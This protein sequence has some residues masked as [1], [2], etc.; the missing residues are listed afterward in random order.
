M[1]WLIFMEMRLFSSARHQPLGHL[2]SRIASAFLVSLLQACFACCSRPPFRWS[3]LLPASFAVCM[4]SLSLS[5]SFLLANI[6]RPICLSLSYGQPYMVPACLPC[7]LSYPRCDPWKGRSNV[8]EWV[9]QRL[10]RC[11]QALRD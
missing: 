3:Q 2:K 5:S 8:V 6:F 10:R 7:L 9:G 11:P 4:L 1:P